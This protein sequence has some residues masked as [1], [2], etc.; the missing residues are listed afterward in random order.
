MNIIPI[1][2]IALAALFVNGCA[3]QQPIQWEKLDPAVAKAVAGDNKFIV[4]VLCTNT[5]WGPQRAYRLISDTGSVKQG[6]A[7]V[8]P[9]CAFTFNTEQPPRVVPSTAAPR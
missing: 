2:S 4:E 5:P 8:S 1:A 9:D 7:G 6:G 3:S